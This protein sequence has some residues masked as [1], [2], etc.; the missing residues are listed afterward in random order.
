MPSSPLSPVLMR[1][2]W[3]GPITWGPLFAGADFGFFW[4][5]C[6][7]MERVR[8]SPL[9][10]VVLDCLLAWLPIELTIYAMIWLFAELQAATNKKKKKKDTYCTWSIVY[11]TLIHYCYNISVRM[12]KQCYVYNIVL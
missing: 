12:L 11:I 5:L 8:C 9:C 4:L 1:Q 6:L 7:L 3:V 2:D 10:A